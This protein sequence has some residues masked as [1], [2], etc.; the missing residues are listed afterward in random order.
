MGFLLT[1][2]RLAD[3]RSFA[4]PNSVLSPAEQRATLLR[5]LDFEPAAVA[6]AVSY[7]DEA[8]GAEDA[9]AADV[10]RA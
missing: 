3:L 4:Y 9:A 1:L 2:E 5:R 8:T 10:P 7:D 6:G